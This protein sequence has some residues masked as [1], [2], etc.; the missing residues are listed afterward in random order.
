MNVIIKYL[1]NGL[2]AYEERNGDAG[3]LSIFDGAPVEVGDALNISDKMAVNLRTGRQTR[4][5]IEDHG[6]Y[7]DDAVALIDRNA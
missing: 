3:V 6:M 4:V 1:K 5:F 7:Y 2:A